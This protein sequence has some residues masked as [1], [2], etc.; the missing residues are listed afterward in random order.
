MKMKSTTSSMS[1]QATPEFCDPVL[2]RVY[3]R[4]G[5]QAMGTVFSERSL[6]STAGTMLFYP[7]LYV[8]DKFWIGM[9]THIV[10]CFLMFVKLW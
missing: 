6:M 7:W 10:T 9:G 8:V 3:C 1:S 5:C 2:A 4:T